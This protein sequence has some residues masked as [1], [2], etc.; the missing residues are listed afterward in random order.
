MYLLEQPTL[1]MVVGVP[2]SGKTSLS[3][4]LCREIVNASYLSKDLIQ[5]E[6]TR[7]ERVTGETYSLI[8]RPAF[9]ILVRFADIHLALGKIPIIDAPFSINHWRSD[10]L[11][12]W[13]SP[14]R[15]TA[16]ERHARLSIVRCVPPD[17]KTLRLRLET[18]GY[19]WDQWKLANWPEFMEREPFRF[20]IAHDDVY[21]VVSDVPV[22]EM[23]QDVLTNHLFAVPG[24]NLINLTIA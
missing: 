21:E 13:V 4:A 18:R 12:D 5:S 8:R 19:S 23:T 14:F 11:S 24:T 6:F 15:A 17:E 3:Q 2:A 16:K 7:D 10:A 22:K 20:P 9:N 1:C